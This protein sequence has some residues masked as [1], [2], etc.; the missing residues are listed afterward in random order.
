MGLTNPRL[1]LRTVSQQVLLCDTTTPLLSF[2]SRPSS[3]LQLSMELSPLLPAVLQVLEGGSQDPS[4]AP[5]PWAITS[6]API[7]TPSLSAFA[8][9]GPPAHPHN[10]LRL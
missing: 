3:G 8:T 2:P 1:S 9:S 6:H 10:P 7:S 5:P 4:A